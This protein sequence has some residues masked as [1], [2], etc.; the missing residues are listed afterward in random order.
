MTTETCTIVKVGG[1]LLEAD[2]TRAAILDAVAAIDGSCILVHGGGDLASAWSARAGIP[3][4]RVQGRR[5]TDAA[6]LEMVTMVYGGLVNRGLVA[7][8]QSR[9][10]NAIGLTG[11]DADCI[12]AVRRPPGEIDYGYVGDIERVRTASFSTLLQAGFLPVV[13]PLTHDGAGGLLNTNADTVAAAIAAA[14]AHVMRTQLVI[15]LDRQGV[16]DAEGAT[17]ARMDAAQAAALEKQG[18]VRDGMLPKLTAAFEARGA[19]VP[20]VVLCHGADLA[21]AA[22]GDGGPW[23]E[24]VA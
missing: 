24:L 3:V 8:L 7:S 17:L 19:G 12:R 23:T 4:H 15:C 14:M 18:T 1:G 5:I 21:D 10:R 13:A 20:R 16:L 2:R 6:S 9:G 11:A 22:A